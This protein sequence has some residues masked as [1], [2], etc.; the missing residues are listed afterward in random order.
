MIPA[1][2]LLAAWYVRASRGQ[3]DNLALIPRN[4]LFRQSLAGIGGKIAS[5]SIGE[6]FSDTIPDVCMCGNILSETGE[7]LRMICPACRDSWEKT[8]WQRAAELVMAHRAIPYFL[9][10]PTEFYP[11]IYA[12]AIWLESRRKAIQ[13]EN[14][15]SQESLLQWLAYSRCVSSEV[16]SG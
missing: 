14:S 1:D 9:Q 12:K 8:R 16:L 5:V 15:S 2:A 6:F 4:Y 7:K 3:L 11:L 13:N 10:C